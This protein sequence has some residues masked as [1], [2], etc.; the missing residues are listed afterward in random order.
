M[1]PKSSIPVVIQTA[2]ADVVTPL[3]TTIDALAT[4]IASDVDQLK[5]TNMFMIFEMV[6]I[7]DVPNMP[8]ATTRDETFLVDTPLAD[9]SRADDTVDVTPSTESH[10]QSNAPSTK[11][12]TDGAT[13]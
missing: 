5:S 2:L 7:P 4:R 6:E 8:P 11:A 12:Q 1:L 9:L 10:D 3:S 13:I